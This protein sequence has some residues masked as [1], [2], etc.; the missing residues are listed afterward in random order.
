MKQASIAMYAVLIILFCSMAG[1]AQQPNTTA[2]KEGAEAPPPATVTGS[3]TTNYIPLWTGSSTV[4]NSK[5]YQTS[6]RIGVGMTAPSV[7]LDVNGRINVSKAYRIQGSDYLSAPGTTYWYTNVGLGYQTLPSLTSA[8]DNI[9]VG[10]QSMF[11]DTTGGNNVG[12]GASTLFTNTTGTNNIAIGGVTLYSNTNGNYNTAV[13]AGVMEYNTIGSENTSIGYQSMFGSTSGGSNT[14]IGAQA[15]YGNTTGGYNT[16]LG[17]Y[18]GAGITSGS[19][20]TMLGYEAGTLVGTGGYDIDIF[21][22]GS[23][24]DNGVIRIGDP[25]YQNSFFVAGVRGVTTGSND[26]VPVV[27]DSNGQLGTVSSS[28]RFKEDIQDMG[29]ASRGLMFLRPVTFRYQKA[30][31]DGSKPVQYG[32]IAEEVE[33]VYPDLVA[34]SAD[35]QIETVK[36]QVLDSMLL[37]EVQRQ[38]EKIRNLEERLAKMEAALAS[39][40]QRQAKR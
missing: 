31:A 22:R 29:E 4:G 39:V 33:E 40:P 20:N 30:F 17:W 27:I 1:N 26:A 7:A 11:S 10:Y 28:R 2:A 5:L 34:H 9:A 21:N 18:A 19:Y 8:T 25:L 12:M 13:G 37:N 15:L 35:G 6:G 38:Q 36:Y 3:G 16:A 24:T 23:T 32:L 14:A